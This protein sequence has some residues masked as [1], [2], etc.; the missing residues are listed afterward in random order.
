MNP[1]APSRPW[2]TKILYD[3][4]YVNLIT[5]SLVTYHKPLLRV[6]ENPDNKDFLPGQSVLVH[7]REKPVISPYIFEW[8]EKKKDFKKVLIIGSGPLEI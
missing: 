2:D 8:K 5:Y 3:I 7:N 4:F 1:E 6:L